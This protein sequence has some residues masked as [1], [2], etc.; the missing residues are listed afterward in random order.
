[1]KMA[2]KRH[3]KSYRDVIYYK[4]HS[5]GTQLVSCSYTAENM[6]QVVLESAVLTCRAAL[7]EMKI[8]SAFSQSS[9][10]VRFP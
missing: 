9:L 4:I 6:G 2:K 1:M 5:L 3:I 10:T 7:C 8:K